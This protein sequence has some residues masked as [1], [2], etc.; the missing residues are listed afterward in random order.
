MSIRLTCDSCKEVFDVDNGSEGKKVRCPEC[1]EKVFVPY[2]G[3]GRGGP[4]RGGKSSMTLGTI[5]LIGF[6][7]TVLVFAVVAVVFMGVSQG[8][9]EAKVIDY[10]DATINSF[11]RM[12]DARLRLI[13]HLRACATNGQRG[14]DAQQ[15]KR[16]LEDVQ[17]AVIDARKEAKAQTVPPAG[18]KF[19]DANMQAFE[20][21][22]QAIEKYD[23]LIAL[24]SANGFPT[25]Q[26]RDEIN[27]TLQQIEDIQARHMDNIC[28]V[29]EE[30]AKA[31]KFRLRRP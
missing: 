8:R 16:E 11:N 22:I 24:V 28:R 18:R 13:N 9:Q 15:L 7:V 23:H 17:K 30:F 10:N 19:H 5:L 14:D 4:R 21:E 2:A 12:D 20:A 6:G 3:N 1:D 31:N 27:L 25:P 26:H 29:Q